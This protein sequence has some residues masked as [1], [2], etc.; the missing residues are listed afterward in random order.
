MIM[1]PGAVPLRYAFISVQPGWILSVVFVTTVA[2][3]VPL[4]S[5]PVVNVPV[6]LPVAVAFVETALI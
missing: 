3:G 2:L 4:G 1:S 5:A 6:A